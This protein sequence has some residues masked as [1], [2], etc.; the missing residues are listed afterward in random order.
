MKKR[1]KQSETEYKVYKNMFESIKHK[2]KKSCYSQKIIEYKDNAKKTWN[3]MKELIGKTR[4]SEPHVPGKVLINEQ[5]VFG[6]EEMVNEFNTFFTNIGAE[7]AKI[8]QMRQG[9]LKVILKKYAQPCQQT[10]LQ[11]TRSKRYFSHLK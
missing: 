3:V 9:H 4:K 8:Y 7:L 6:K 5:E 2:S 10:L 1:T 11:L